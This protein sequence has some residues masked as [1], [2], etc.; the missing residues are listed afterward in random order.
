MTL[1]Q[2]P[3]NVAHSYQLSSTVVSFGFAGRDTA[4]KEDARFLNVPITRDLETEQQITLVVTPVE[5]SVVNGTGVV[6]PPVPQYDPHNPVNATGV[7]RM[8]SQV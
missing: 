4:E 7:C 1:R 8:S 3:A 5:Y 2:Y 6:L